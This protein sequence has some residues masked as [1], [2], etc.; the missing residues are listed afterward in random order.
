MFIRSIQIF[1]GIYRQVAMNVSRAITAL[2]ENAIESACQ[3][4]CDAAGR[5]EATSVL[6]RVLTTMPKKSFGIIRENTHGRS[7]IQSRWFHKV[8]AACA[9]IARDAQTA[10]EPTIVTGSNLQDLYLDC[11]EQIPPRQR[12]KLT[13]SM[14]R[15]DQA[16]GSMKLNH[17]GITV[18]IIGTVPGTGGTA[19]ASYLKASAEKSLFPSLH[20]YSSN[21]GEA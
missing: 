10:N 4:L 15:L 11:K 12:D 5:I 13:A 1:E 18:K 8:Q 20:L 9:P 7:A 14:K 17:W 19:G 2:N 6:Y 3:V 16:W 21:G